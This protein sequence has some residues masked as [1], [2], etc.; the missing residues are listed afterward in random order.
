[1][2]SVK[3]YTQFFHFALLAVAIIFCYSD[4]L[5]NSW[6]FDDEPNIVKNENIRIQTLDWEDIKK[7]F[8]VS[9]SGTITRPVALVSFALNYMFSGFDTTSYHVV[10]ICIH[11]ISALFVYLVFLNTLYLYREK[12]GLRGN[13]V[14]E[15]DVALLG[16]ALWAIHPI[17]TQAVTY[18]VQREASMAAMFCMVAMYCYLRFRQ[19][20]GAMRQ[21]L[22]LFLA[23]LFW[24]IGIG[25]KE[26]VAMLPLV[27]LGYEVAFFKTSL[28]EKK[29]YVILLF[30]VFLIVSISAFLF[31][32]G[33][34]FSY[35][36]AL[37]SARPYTMWQRLITQPIILSRYLFLVI[38]PLA[39]FLSLETDIFASASLISPPQTIFA[40]VFILSL[41]LF[42][43][44]S[45]KKF[46]VIGFALYFYFINQIIE[47][48]FIGLELYFEH[49]NYLPS[50]FIYFCLSWYFVKLLLYYRGLQKPFM[51]GVLV[52]AMI[53]VLIS[54]GNAT[55]LRNDI[56]K[57][58]I[59]LLSD[60][61]EKAPN[62]IRPYISLGVKYM[63]INQVEKAKD[64]YKQAE[65][66]YK[67]NPEIHQ[68]DWVALLYHNAGT[69][70]MREKKNEKAIRLLLKAIDIDPLSWETHVNLG[71]LFFITGDVK[72]AQRALVNAV[73]IKPEKAEIYSMLG[74]A[75]YADN[76]YELAI[77]ALKRGIELD[78][79]RELQLNLVAVY[80][81][82]KN[83]Q[84][85]KSVFLRMASSPDDLIYQLY[86][87][88]FSSGQER[89]RSL[90]QVAEMMAVERK[91]YCSWIKEVKG[92]NSPGL[93]YPE[94]FTHLEPEL[95]QIYRKK[96]SQLS[97]L[98][99]NMQNEAN[100]CEIR[101][102]R[103]S[104]V[105]E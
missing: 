83:Q 101:G 94:E 96:I 81:A 95:R 47:S 66:I 50:I 57:T 99:V 93:I 27:L 26:N 9:N 49:R 74:R 45:L 31:M 63:A 22:L 46:P 105:A 91:D 32:R 67:K 100:D 42:S 15:Q 43:I 88:V 10:N 60:S 4:S 12:E 79:L 103:G 87:A 70:A 21:R 80:L 38:C 24:I 85:A 62:N 40:N 16:A 54:E 89:Q 35:I 1:M 20:Q 8:R 7:T 30:A 13:E 51:H 14:F 11:I 82:S 104:S 41:T 52:L 56:W 5:D 28:L 76:K 44:L 23:L 19:N 3:F 17:Q 68:K 36:E 64:L 73:E 29:K 39:D 61:V 77:A 2:Y 18:I 37:Y 58:E 71:Y 84:M 59:D 48:S 97:D 72:N 98:F 65:K 78:K 92:N 55:Y 75:L 6:H 102:A 25:T 86:R 34:I 90:E 33:G 53:C 69:A